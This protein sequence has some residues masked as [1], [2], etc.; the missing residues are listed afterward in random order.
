MPITNLQL[1]GL[2]TQKL[3]LVFCYSVYQQAQTLSPVPKHH[4]MKA[5][6]QS[7]DAKH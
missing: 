3:N 4:V 5:Y 7:G 1:R 2:G 6:R